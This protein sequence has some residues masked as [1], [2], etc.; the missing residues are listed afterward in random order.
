MS[1][2][3]VTFQVRERNKILLL[4]IWNNQASARGSYTQM[5]RKEG[6]SRPKSP[7]QYLIKPCFY[8]I[9]KVKDSSTSNQH[10]RNTAKKTYS[11]FVGA[12]VNW[13]DSPTLQYRYMPYTKK[14]G[15]CSGNILLLTHPSIWW[16]HDVTSNS[17]IANSKTIFQTH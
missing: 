10:Q 15:F 5:G 17:I 6:I 16:W 3:I 12:T 2:V 11:Q 1:C 13:P 7:N 4:I 14:Q 9:T 8:S